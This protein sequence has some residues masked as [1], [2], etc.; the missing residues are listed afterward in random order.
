MA[1]LP[2]GVRRRKDGTLEKRFTIKGVRYSIYGNTTKEIAEKE[3]ETRNKIEQG[4]YKKNSNILLDEYFAEWLNRKQI[5]TKGNSLKT[6]KSIYNNHLKSRIGKCK[7]KDIERRQVMDLQSD[8]T[9]N[10]SVTTCNY[11][12]S[13]LKIILND[14]VKDEILA[15][16]P[17][18]NI[19][20]IKD[21]KGNK[22]ANESYHR[23]LTAE[24][25][26]LFMQESRDSYYYELFAL[27]L[28]TGMRLGEILALTW[29]DID[30][31]N[32]VIHITKTQTYNIDNK[33]D[34]GTTK[35]TAGKRD[36]PITPN[37]KQVLKKQREKMGNVYSIDFKNDNVFISLFGKTIYNSAI[38][39]EI[40][41]VVKRLN[42]KG[43]NMEHFTAHAFRDTFAT[44]YLEQGGN[45]KTLQKL[46][47]HSSITMTMDIYA[48]VLPDTMQDEMQKIVI[49]I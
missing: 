36:I 13:V 43:Y 41:R 12:I 35:T 47:G 20:A 49:N 2:Q 4:L 15:K 30:Y 24:E 18:D 23:A 28:C 34:T 40:S 25:Q 38:N 29:G 22:K 42:E 31:I 33:V 46:L 19:K 11:I 45:M 39:S 21:I 9:T 48:H 5:D 10:Y 16:N 3:Q 8:L 6:Y 7:V 17:A 37:I 14:A 32:N 26:K 27:A 1:R 44:R